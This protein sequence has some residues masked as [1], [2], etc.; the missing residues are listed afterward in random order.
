VKIEKGRE[1]MRQLRGRVSGLCQPAYMLDLPGG[2]GKL[3]IGPN[4]IHETDQP[5]IYRV[6]DFNDRSHLY[7]PRDEHQKRMMRPQSSAN[8]TNDPAI[9]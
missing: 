1:L 5:E 3:P 7:P 4:Y 6:S 2:D 8:R 9:V